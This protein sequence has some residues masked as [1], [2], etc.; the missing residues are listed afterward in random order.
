[1]NE[2][3][4]I[5]PPKT[6]QKSGSTSWIRTR[7]L[8]GLGPT[9][10]D[11]RGAQARLRRGERLETGGGMESLR[12]DRPPHTVANE[13]LE[14]RSAPALD[15]DQGV[16]GRR[17]HGASKMRSTRR[18]RAWIRKDSRVWGRSSRIGSSTSRICASGRPRKPV[19][20]RGHRPLPVS[21][22]TAPGW[23]APRGSEPGLTAAPTPQQAMCWSI[24]T[25]PSLSVTTWTWAF[26]GAGITVFPASS[27]RVAPRVGGSAGGSRKK[28]GEGGQE[29]DAGPERVTA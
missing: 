16:G 29:W 9:H 24:S 27:T 6:G 1:M 17:R 7:S 26:T 10:R 25:R 12:S 20:I 21:P 28:R 11:H 14:T 15:P 23:P 22:R 2:M 3:M 18:S 5:S 4:C 19:Q 8:V 13:P